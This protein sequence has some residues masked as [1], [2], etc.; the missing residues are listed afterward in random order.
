[1][2]NRSRQHDSAYQI[3]Q[4][5]WLL[6]VL[7]AFVSSLIVTLTRLVITQEKNKK[8]KENL[9]DLML[10]LLPVIASGLSAMASGTLAAVS[11]VPVVG[12]AVASGIA[13]GSAAVGTAVTAGAVEAGVAT[14]TA[15][16]LGSIA[17]S[18]TTLAAGGA[19]VE[20]GCEVLK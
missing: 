5:V 17:S 15:A 19:V 12:S 20:K 3:I 2:Q 14:A 4:S 10:F 18:S 6:P 9:E 11:A 8:E 7:T 16:S 1:M 13:A